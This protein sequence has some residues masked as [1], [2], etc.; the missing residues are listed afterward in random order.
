MKLLRLA[1]F[2]A[3]LVLAADVLP[4]TAAED[5]NPERLADELTE[6]VFRRVVRRL[7]EHREDERREDRDEDWDEDR[8]EEERDDEDD[9]DEDEERERLEE[10]MAEPLSQTLKL[11]FS[12]RPK[13][14]GFDTVS[15]A[16]ATRSYHLNLQMTNRQKDEEVNVFVAGAI[17]EL[18]DGRYLIVYQLTVHSE[19]P[20]KITEINANG[21]VIAKIGQS[22]QLTQVMGRALVLELDAAWAQAPQAH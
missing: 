21:S 11:D 5:E 17:R 10:Q 20:Q 19:G 12:L 15:V 2:A 13:D 6:A 3:L 7:R 4:V 18:D 8:E 9:D 14:G 1:V 16:T 22:Y